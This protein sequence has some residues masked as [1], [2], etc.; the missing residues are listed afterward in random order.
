MVKVQPGHM[1]K[2]QP[3]KQP[4]DMVKVQ[5]DNNLVTWLKYNQTT[6]WSHG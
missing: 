2:V 5:P 1:V 6:T 3:D 4:G